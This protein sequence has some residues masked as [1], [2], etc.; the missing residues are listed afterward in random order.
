[1][2]IGVPKEIKIHEYRVGLTPFAAH[3]YV[4]H[5]HKVLI[6]KGAGEGIGASDDEYI[7]NGAVI[8]DNA[9]NIFEQSDM[10]I[11]VKEPQ[12][13]EC[14]MLRE[15]QILYTYLHLAADRK[16]T[17]LLIKSKAIAI[18]YETIT[19]DEGRLPL[20]APMSEVA[21]RMSIQAGAH[22]LEKKQ[23]G[24]G[25]LLAGVPGVPPANVLIIGG[26]VAGYNAARMAVGLGADV[27]ILDK[28]QKQ[29]RH[30]DDIFKGSVRL[31]MS[32][33]RILIKELERADLVIGAALVVGAA[34]PKIIKRAH[35]QHMQKG[36]AIVDISIDQGGIAETSKATTHDN[37]SFIIDDIVHYCVANMPGAVAR[38]SAFALNAATLD[39]GLMLANLGWQKAMEKSN[40]LK[41]GLNIC[42]GEIMHP[43]VQEAFA[44]L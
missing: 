15:G 16:Q 8:V 11:K 13:H 14:E 34:A 35:L 37:P 20:L 7:Q 5:G 1:M 33:E 24:R 44:D 2:I 42:Q 36:S 10:I 41:N 39:Y 19:D 23:G 29:L 17:E 28:S 4:S 3:E 27:T 38:T 32:N 31:L 18:A 40:H 43:A 21:G 25:V 6:E 26:G 9:A 30:L 22:I 12:P